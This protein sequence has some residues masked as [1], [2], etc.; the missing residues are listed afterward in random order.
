[1]RVNHLIFTGSKVFNFI[2]LGCF[3]L[4]L[5]IVATIAVAESGNQDAVKANQKVAKPVVD[6]LQSKLAGA[7]PGMKIVSAVTTS[8]PGIF[9]VGL[10][11]GPTVYMSENGDYF[12]IGQLFKVSQG[13]LTNMTEFKKDGMRAREMADLNNDEAI[14]FGA[15]GET[16]ARITVFTDVDCG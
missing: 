14:I 7:R 13:E 11:A 8:I 3:G 5:C 16:K 9:E 6:L 4:V 1:M 10:S 2:K 15:E 12:I